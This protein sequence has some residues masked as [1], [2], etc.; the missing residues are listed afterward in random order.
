LNRLV[1]YVSTD[2]EHC[3]AAIPQAIRAG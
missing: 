1:T 3:T 2:W